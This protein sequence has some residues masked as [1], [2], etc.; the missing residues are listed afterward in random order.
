[1]RLMVGLAVPLLVSGC[2][3]V[4]PQLA[5]LGYAADGVSYAASGKSTTDHALSAALERDCRVL[6]VVQQ[7]RICRSEP[8]ADEVVAFKADD[9]GED[10]IDG[11]TDPLQADP[12]EDPVRLPRDLADLAP[13]LG[14]VA[15]VAEPDG[16]AHTSGFSADMFLVPSHPGGAYDAAIRDALASGS[17]ASEPLAR[18]PLASD[19]L[20][21]ESVE[22][23][24]REAESPAVTAGIPEGGSQG[25]S[26]PA[27][28]P[29]AESPLAP[30]PLLRGQ[31][32][33]VA[34]G[35]LSDSP[36]PAAPS[37]T[38]SAPVQESSPDPAYFVVFGSFSS[39]DNAE[40]LAA[41]E[42]LYIST[43][44]PEARAGAGATGQGAA[45]S[46][47]YRVHTAPL[48]H[49]AARNLVGSRS[50]AGLPR[51]WIAPSCDAARTACIAPSF[52]GNPRL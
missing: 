2:A 18:E 14:P 26:E 25:E 13:Y 5:L 28:P 19:T 23:D 37:A 12:L 20:V 43:F 22:R 11:L 8:D 34:A 3:F 30:P 38:A 35:S 27:S 4:P 36:A 15:R 29:L 39:K 33:P 17:L 48:T 52:Q 42:S 44:V 9:S 24:L 40:R 31:G 10:R 51:P 1:M 47:M 7:E 46:I 45:P 6:R 32:G 50:L 49:E 16:W 41:R 21:R